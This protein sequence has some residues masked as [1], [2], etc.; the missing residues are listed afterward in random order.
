MVGISRA[1]EGSQ[2]F[3]RVAPTLDGRV[4]GLDGQEGYLN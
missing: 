1:A 3:S 4:D 2:P